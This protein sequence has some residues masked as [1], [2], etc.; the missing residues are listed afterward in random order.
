MRISYDDDPEDDRLTNLWQ[1][2]CRRSIGSKAGQLALRE[3]EAALLALPNKRLIRNGVACDGDVCAVGAYVLLKRAE[4]AGSSLEVAL[5]A[6]EVEMGPAEDQEWIE[7]DE[8]GVEYGMPKLVAWSLVALNDMQLDTKYVT[9]EG[10]VE[11]KWAG[12]AYHAGYRVEVEITP[13][14]RYQR[15][16][17]WVRSKLKAEAA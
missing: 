9:C 12:H 16:L 5:P 15:V 11:R 2:N 4:R 7:T 3:L 8:L 17:A 1:G 14:E 6:F 13:E 10:P